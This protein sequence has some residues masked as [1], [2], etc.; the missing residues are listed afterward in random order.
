MA[1]SFGFMDCFLSGPHPYLNERLVSS[2]TPTIRSAMPTYR[3]ECFNRTTRFIEQSSSSNI[4]FLQKSFQDTSLIFNF[5]YS[6]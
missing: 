6:A 3:Y 1:T 4:T 5:K 2:R